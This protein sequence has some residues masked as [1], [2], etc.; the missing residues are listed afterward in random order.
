MIKEW[1]INFMCIIESWLQH[2]GNEQVIASIKPPRFEV[3]STHRIGGKGGGIAFIYQNSF[4]SVKTNALLAKSLE[5]AS[6][7]FQA[8]SKTI[9]ITAV[10]RTPPSKANKSY[11]T[12]FIN[13]LQELVIDFKTND[14]LLTGN[15][16]FHNEKD[17]YKNYNH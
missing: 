11:P 2:T 13:E 16:N 12:D 1:N 10:Y 6:C 5:A 7:S 17:A 15:I 9:H 14:F 3:N 4:K 8:D